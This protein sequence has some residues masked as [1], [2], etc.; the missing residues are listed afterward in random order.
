MCKM[1]KDTCLIALKKKI[2]IY[3]ILEMLIYLILMSSSAE[4]WKCSYVSSRMNSPNTQ[5]YNHTNSIII[6]IRID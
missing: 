6:R 3:F 4:S 1:F 5:A 2:L